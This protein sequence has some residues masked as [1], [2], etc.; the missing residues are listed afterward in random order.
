MEKLFILSRRG[1]NAP[2]NNRSKSNGGNERYIW[3]T[4]APLRRTIF[5]NMFRAAAAGWAAGLRVKVE[6]NYTT[7]P[8]QTLTPH[9]VNKQAATTTRTMN[10][11]R[12]KESVSFVVLKEKKVAKDALN[13][14][15]HIGNFTTKCTVI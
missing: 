5:P 10:G 13:L 12:K 8:Q 4:V 15:L 7:H 6:T 3:V 9:K 2:G 1:Q 11:S 14:G